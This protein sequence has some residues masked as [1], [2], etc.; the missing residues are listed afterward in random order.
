M[1]QNLFGTP[2][3]LGGCIGRPTQD[4]THAQFSVRDHRRLKY[5]G[6]LDA[7]RCDG[8]ILEQGLVEGCPRQ[9]QRSSIATEIICYVEYLPGRVYT[10][11][12]NGC[13]RER[14]VV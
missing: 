8:V 11:L 13:L 3:S 2:V 7:E 5:K 12:S 6:V 9:S 10:A 1:R 14:R 4:I